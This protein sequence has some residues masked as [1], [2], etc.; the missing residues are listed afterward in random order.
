MEKKIIEFTKILTATYMEKLRYPSDAETMKF[1]FKHDENEASEVNVTRIR[2][3]VEN[4]SDLW[5]DGSLGTEDSS[6]LVRKH[7]NEFIGIYDTELQSISEL[8]AAVFDYDVHETVLKYGDTIPVQ[9]GSTLF[10][11]GYCA[12]LILGPDLDPPFEG[13]F[14]R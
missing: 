11:R 9:R 4:E 6:F 12:A 13:R 3:P 8:I 2:I 7:I 5:F 10:E 1:R 14:N